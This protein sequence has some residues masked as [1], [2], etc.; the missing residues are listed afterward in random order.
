[1]SLE[2]WRTRFRAD[3]QNR[4][5][6]LPAF[7]TLQVYLDLLVATV[8]GLKSFVE[9]PGNTV[10]VDI[11]LGPEGSPSAPAWR[12]C[13]RCSA[14]CVQH[15]AVT[16]VLVVDLSGLLRPLLCRPEML[17]MKATGQ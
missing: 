17:L 1:M 4:Q 13:S 2:C 5:Q 11:V 12:N 8:A 15:R 6:C 16:H 9:T 10:V 7:L 14:S 3:V